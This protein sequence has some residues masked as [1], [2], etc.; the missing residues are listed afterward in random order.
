MPKYVFHFLDLV[1]DIYTVKFIEVNSSI[2]SG[3]GAGL[4]WLFSQRITADISDI[5]SPSTNI[6]IELK[7]TNNPTLR[8]TL[9]N[10]NTGKASFHLNSTQLPFN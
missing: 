10:T 7:N 4:F 1:N 6:T 2:N 5:G 9:S 3:I 8:Q